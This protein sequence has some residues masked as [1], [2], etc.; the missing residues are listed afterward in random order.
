M[1]FAT[2]ALNSLG[3]LAKG[4]PPKSISLCLK[5]ASLTIALNS[6]FI[7]STITGEIFAGPATPSHYS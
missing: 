3:L 1:S 7:R 4:L 6:L 2:L 5:S